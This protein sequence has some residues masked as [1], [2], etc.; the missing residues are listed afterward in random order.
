M[1]IMIIVTSQLQDKEKPLGDLGTFFWLD[2]IFQKTKT[3]QMGY[4]RKKVSDRKCM[5]GLRTEGMVGS[6]SKALLDTF[7]SD[8]RFFV[9]A[10][11]ETDNQGTFS[12]CNRNRRGRNVIANG[13]KKGNAVSSNGIRKK[14][15][16]S[17]GRQILNR[18]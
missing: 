7:F 1:K 9:R 3:Y 4:K 18:T 12:T 2:E 17:K 8:F 14:K 11:Q 16:K 5:H 13:T 6:R 15:K 10:D